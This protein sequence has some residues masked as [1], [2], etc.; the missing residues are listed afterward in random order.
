VRDRQF[1][2]DDV[3]LERGGLSLLL[4]WR[5][6]SVEA[7]GIDR[8]GGQDVLGASLGMSVV[9]AAACPVAASELGDGAFDAGADAVGAQPVRAGLLLAIASLEFM[10]VAGR[11]VDGPALARPGARG[12]ARAGI[13]QALAGL[14][15][16][17]RRPPCWPGV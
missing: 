1:T 4:T 15:H 12:P 8:D 14:H 16:D 13:A 2:S 9:A 6:V 10:Q 17:D 7:L 3:F 5:F 11:K